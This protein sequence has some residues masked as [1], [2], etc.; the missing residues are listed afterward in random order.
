M[1][2]RGDQPENGKMSYS[3]DKLSLPGYNNCGKIIIKYEFP[4]G[5]QEVQ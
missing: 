4:A 3:T 2:L 5:K 1:P